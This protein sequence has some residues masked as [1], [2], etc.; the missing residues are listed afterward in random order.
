M[1]DPHD[2]PPKNADDG[3][4]R[5]HGFAR[6]LPRFLRQRPQDKPADDAPKAMPSADMATALAG[7]TPAPEKPAEAQ[8]E[9]VPVAA[10]PRIVGQA[11]IPG[12]PPETDPFAA[13]FLRRN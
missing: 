9:Q 2:S 11:F 5:A 4:A 7:L 10:P 12:K 6:G 13:G 1:T 8:P 3:A